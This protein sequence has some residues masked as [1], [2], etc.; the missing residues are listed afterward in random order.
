[1]RMVQ[2]GVMGSMGDIKLKESL[3]KMAKSLGREIARRKALLLFGFEG[4]FESLPSIA[5]QSAEKEGGRAISFLQGSQKQNLNELKS[6]Q[7]ITG[8]ARGGGR[9]FSFVLSCDVLICIGGGS[10]TLIEIAMAYQAGIPIVAL[11][12]SGGWSSKLANKFLDERKREKIVG[13]KTA[14]EAVDLALSLV[15]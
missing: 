13:A 15:K 11:E 4:D 6:I 14:E 3:K 2:I 1:M 8:Q 9:E 12:K 7:I 5:A 10:G